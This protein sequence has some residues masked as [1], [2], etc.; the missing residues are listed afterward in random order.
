M[1][2]D[3]QVRYQVYNKRLYEFQKHVSVH[4]YPQLDLVSWPQGWPAGCVQ[5]RD[6]IFWQQ[7][8]AEHD[9]H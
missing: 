7:F 9:R 4:K 3:D 8:P 1:P 2:I 6:Q 5:T